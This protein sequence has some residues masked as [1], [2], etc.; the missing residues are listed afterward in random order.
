MSSKLADSAA[1]ADTSLI[2]S[3]QVSPLPI[4]PGGNNPTKRQMNE[5]NTQ[6]AMMTAQASANTKYDPPVPQPITKQ[7]TIEKFSSGSGPI[8][9]TLLVIGGLLVVYGFIAK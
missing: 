5:T 9:S 7:V 4:G 1:P 3:K 2:R 6:L 8:P